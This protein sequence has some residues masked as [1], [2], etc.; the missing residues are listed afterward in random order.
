MKK[1]YGLKWDP[2]LLGSLMKAA[3]VDIS[4]VA[5]VTDASISLVIAWLHGKTVPSTKAFVDLADL[6][7][8][9]L[10]Y[11]MGRCSKEEAKNIQEGYEEYFKSR[12]DAAWMKYLELK[13]EGKKDKIPAGI[14]SPWPYN[15]LEEIM[16]EDYTEYRPEQRNGL[17]YA[18][19]LLPE[20]SREMLEEFF[21]DQ[22]TLREIGNAHNVT[23]ERARQ[24]IAKAVKTLRSPEMMKA[25]HEGYDPGEELL[26]EQE[27]RLSAWRRSLTEEEQTLLTKEEGLREI[28]KAVSVLEQSVTKTAKQYGM[29]LIFAP[30]E[31]ESLLTPVDKLALSGRARNALLRAEIKTVGQIVHTGARGLLEIRNI[32]RGYA[33]EIH[34]AVFRE[35][36]Y[37][38][39]S[40]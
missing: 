36:G 19:G 8:V 40:C 39:G 26:K 1:K 33:I 11:L 32:G 18:L 14:L 29:R 9:S 13:R 4:T 24:V 21:R 10:D 5:S 22:K 30:A 20:R 25:L 28:Q 27:H 37:D 16:G 12:L 3:G 6:F 2:E 23:Q 15:L 34:D 38:I 35:T 31:P 7:G 17:Q